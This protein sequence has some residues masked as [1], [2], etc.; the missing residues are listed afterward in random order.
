ML[1]C[2]TQ[3]SSCYFLVADDV[4]EVLVGT[5]RANDVWL[6]QSVRRYLPRTEQQVLAV[7]QWLL[8][9]RFHHRAVG[10]AGDLFERRANPSCLSVS[11][12]ADPDVRHFF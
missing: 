5:H 10:L 7:L 12:L 4:A 1:I 11:L 8:G 3:E 2:R 9:L 6:S